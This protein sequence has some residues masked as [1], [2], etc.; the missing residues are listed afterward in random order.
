MDSNQSKFMLF[1]LNLLRKSAKR[2]GIATE[3]YRLSIISYSPEGPANTV[4]RVAGAVK[5]GDPSVSKFENG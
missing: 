1:S 3:L 5:S 2:S 4:P